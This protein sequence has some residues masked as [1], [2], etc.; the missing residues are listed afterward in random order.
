L[1]KKFSGLQ[2]FTESN[3][4]IKFCITCGARATHEALFIVGDGAILVEKYCEPCAAKE[5]K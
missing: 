5:V 4:K 1:E 2:P 3:G